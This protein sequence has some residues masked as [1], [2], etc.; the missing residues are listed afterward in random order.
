MN[1]WACWPRMTSLSS[2]DCFFSFYI[3][4]EYFLWKTEFADLSANFDGPSDGP[5][6]PVGFFWSGISWYA[7]NHV[8]LRSN[9]HYD[10]N[11]SLSRKCKISFN[12][13]AIRMWCRIHDFRRSK[14]QNQTPSI[15]FKRHLPV[16]NRRLTGETKSLH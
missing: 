4:L 16:F 1:F 13:I 10:F 14:N 6:G 15:G 12:S 5:S 8:C 7:L 2:S 11:L 3:L 9:I